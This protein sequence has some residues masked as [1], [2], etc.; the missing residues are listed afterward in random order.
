[1][2]AQKMSSDSVENL[3]DFRLFAVLSPELNVLK[4]RYDHY[5]DPLFSFPKPETQPSSKEAMH[6]QN[7]P[8]S[9]TRQ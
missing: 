2:I 6:G 7:Q 4:K 5:L 9:T 8:D 3:P 1:M